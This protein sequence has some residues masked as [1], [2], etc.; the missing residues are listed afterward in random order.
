MPAIDKYNRELAETVN[1][2][3]SE[4]KTDPRAEEIADTHFGG[5]AVGGEIIDGIRKR[6][7]TINRIIE[8]DYEHLSCVVSEKY[9]TLVRSGQLKLFE[10]TDA[11]AQKCL[12]IGHGNRSEGIRLCTESNDVIYQAAVKQGLASGTGLVTAGVGRARKAAEHGHIPEDRAARFAQNLN[13]SLDIP[14]VGEM[15]KLAHQGGLKSR[16]RK[17]Q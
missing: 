6:L 7:P 5:K 1:K 12:P 4:Q 10:M 11:E 8:Q 9:Y 14:K 15:R 13:A 17:K 2:L 16:R 3:F